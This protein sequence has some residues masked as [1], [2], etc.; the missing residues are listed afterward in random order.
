MGPGSIILRILTVPHAY[1]SGA[2]D[3]RARAS[4]K[5]GFILSLE[6]FIEVQSFL[7]IFRVGYIEV[8]LYTRGRENK[9]G[10]YEI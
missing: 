7:G 1:T 3:K 4:A 9:R 2:E 8:G 10:K 5:G 6:N